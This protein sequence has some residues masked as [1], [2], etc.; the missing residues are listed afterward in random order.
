MLI[1]KKLIS[2]LKWE[3]ES[4]INLDQEARLVVIQVEH[5]NAQENQVLQVSVLV[6]TWYVQTRLSKRRYKILIFEIPVLFIFSIFILWVERKTK[7]KQ[8]LK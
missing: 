6:S 8:L 5:L 1:F 4:K 7:N 3:N 2:K